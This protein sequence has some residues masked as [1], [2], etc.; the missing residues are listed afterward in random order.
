VGHSVL[1]NLGYRS[2]K[3]D[4]QF[5][6][7]FVRVRVRVRVRVCVCVWYIYLFHYLLIF[8]R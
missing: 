8:N 7:G 2:E 6:L 3:C 1:I 5:K 4:T